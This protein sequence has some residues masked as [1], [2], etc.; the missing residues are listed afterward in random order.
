MLATLDRF[1]VREAQPLDAAG[2]GKVYVESWRSS[3]RGILPAAYLAS[4]DPRVRAAAYRNNLSDGQDLHLV[5]YDT[6]HL[7]IVGFCDAGA[8]R[9]PGA[10]YEIYTLYL[11]DHAKLH[12]LGRAF[13]DAVRDRLRGSLMIW[14]L[15][16]NQ[17]ARG[18]YEALGGR[19][20]SS[21]QSRIGGATVTEVSYVWEKR[22]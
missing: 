8:A 16:R 21:V 1:A 17:H 10:A 5:A 22:P 20:G 19:R 7:D 15:E 4:L 6:T 13:F 9:R 12:G 3:Y 18:F 2:I 11:L 14:V